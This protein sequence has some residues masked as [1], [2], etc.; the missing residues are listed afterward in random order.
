[1]GSDPE[2]EQD[3][4]IASPTGR[5]V[6]ALCALATF[7]SIFPLLSLLHVMSH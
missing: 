2:K 4:P 3:E 5:D 1:M 6:F 7:A